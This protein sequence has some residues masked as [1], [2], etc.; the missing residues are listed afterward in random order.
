MRHIELLLH[1]ILPESGQP[2]RVSPRPALSMGFQVPTVK[3]V[4]LLGVLQ[5][6]LEGFDV[7]VNYLLGWQGTYSGFI[8]T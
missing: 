4:A 2:G 7:V 5:D 1:R 6:T 8:E 3:R